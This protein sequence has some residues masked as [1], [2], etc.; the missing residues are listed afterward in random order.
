MTTDG[1]GKKISIWEALDSWGKSLPGWQKF[2]VSYAVRD[3]KLSDQRIDEAYAIYLRGTNLSSDTTPLP[4]IPDS[5]TGRTDGTDSSPVLI[6]GIKNPVN[7]NAIPGTAEL[8][9]GNGLTVVYG[10]NGAGKS[11]FARILAAACFSRSRQQIL[12]NVY[13]AAAST[14][15]ASADILIR[16]G[17]AQD[18]TLSVTQGTE[19]AVLRR[20]SVFDSAI[21]RVHL[22][23]ETPLGFQPAGFDVFDEV[24]RVIDAI[25]KRLDGDIAKRR[26][27]NKFVNIFIGESAIKT[28]IG[29]LSKCTDTAALR[30]LAVYGETEAGRL[31]EVDGQIAELKTKSPADLI[32]QREAAKK[33][34]AD[35]QKRMAG[36]RQKL[37]AAAC[38]LFAQQVNDLKSKIA[39]AMAASLADVGSAALKKTGSAA[40]E[41]FAKSARQLGR[42]E[43]EG[44]PRAGD[45]CL[46]CH[47]P[48]DEP[49]ASLVQRFWS[50]LDDEARVAAERANA[51]LNSTV[52]DLK[53]TDLVPLAAEG[54][55]RADLVRVVPS[56][57]RTVDEFS[58]QLVARRDQ[59]VA[60]LENKNPSLPEGEISGID[61]TIASCQQALDAEIKQLAENSV[62]AALA[63]REAEHVLLRHRQVLSQN[64]DDVCAYIDNLKWIDKASTAKR[65][66]TTRFVTDK[67]KE[68]FQTL[69]EGN[70]KD[71]LKEECG[72]LDALLPIEFKARGSGGKTLRGLQMQ[73]GHKPNDILSEGE[74]RAVALADFLTEVNLNPSSAGIVLDDPVTSLDHKRKRQ[75]AA[76]LAREAKV[77]Q[78]IIF[79]HD[80]VFLSR[81]MDL[82]KEGG[83]E[84]STH[85]VDRGADGAPGHVM[86]DDC[87]ANSDAYKTPH[88]AKESLAKAKKG[89]GKTRVDAL[90]A[91]A[92][93]LR[94]TVEEIIIR[95]LFKG[96][97]KRWDEQVKIGNLKDIE[98][99]NDVAD[100]ICLLQDDIS[101]LIDAHSTSDEFGGGMPEPDELEKLIARVDAM[102][103][104]A[105]KRRKGSVT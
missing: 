14:A 95:D 70:Y 15:P 82:A 99:S 66:L 63:S 13:D 74:Q 76:R 100:E 65:S 28:E 73:G 43:S 20:V 48:L 85:W 105:K 40:W 92:S 33:D 64:I 59:I 26:S 88:R 45:P 32:K 3:G 46:L 18:E 44:Y 62:D 9:F 25:S 52:D 98:W 30:K 16:R 91:G 89:I 41:T 7:V 4:A 23:E 47:R 19:H 80:L 55:M 12:P 24:A 79:T 27:E 36:H 39:A 58:A 103:A 61:D 67:Q 75:I 54:R 90:R 87:P 21:A 35:L 68:L 77:R 60:Y 86:L 104:N 34:M 96:T 22:A 37:G 42:E 81:L 2:T 5:I 1:A 6:A 8:H 72:Q 31:A 10:H 78:V 93:A 53:R 97:V 84:I 102:Q 69:I 51:A 94:Q 57:V 38:T 17:Q 83:I 101:R 29:K 56:L 11:G 50:F 71:R 49:S